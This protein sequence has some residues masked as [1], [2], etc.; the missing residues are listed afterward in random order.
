MT[1][2]DSHIVVVSLPLW[3][4]TRP[5]CVFIAKLQK[6]SGCLVTFFVA[7][8]LYNKVKAE[9]ARQYNA[10]DEQEQEQLK[11]IR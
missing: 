5:L 10:K 9:I 1:S 11:R 4:H 2:S 3:G 7:E 8:L 6:E